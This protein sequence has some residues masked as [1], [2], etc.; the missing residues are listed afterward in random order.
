MRHTGRPTETIDS[1]KKGEGT[2]SV[3]CSK[4]QRHTYN[5]IIDTH[6][7]IISYR[8]GIRQG[9]LCLQRFIGIFLWILLPVLEVFDVHVDRLGIH[10][11]SRYFFFD[12]FW[13]EILVVGL[14][15][16]LQLLF[17]VV[18]MIPLEEQEEKRQWY[19][20]VVLCCC[21]CVHILVVVEQH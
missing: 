21:F 17:S 7:N 20:S 10:H 11:E 4:S 15:F 19:M 9:E 16:R 5:N 13:S 1:E 6:N 18:Y 2:V 14:K 8:F 12:P 3:G